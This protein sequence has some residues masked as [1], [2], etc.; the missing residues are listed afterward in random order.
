[1][2]ALAAPA[3][4]PVKPGDRVRTPAGK[5]RLS[6]VTLTSPGV[7]ANLAEAVSNEVY[8]GLTRTGRFTIVLGD[9]IALWLSQQAIAPESVIGGAGVK[10]ALDRFKSEHALVL[11]VHQ[12][13]RKPFMDARLFSAARAEP[14]LS[15]SAFVPP[16]VKPVQPGRFSGTVAA[17]AQ[18]EKQQRSLLA[19]LLGWGDDPTAYSAADS[20]IQL[21]EVARFPFALVGMDVAVSPADKIPRLAVTDGER[22]YMYRVVNRALEAEWTFYARWLGRVISVQLADL[23]GDGVLEVVAN[24]F[25]TKVGMSSLIVGLRKGK[26]EELADSYD[27]LLLAVDDEGKGIRHTLWAQRYVEE[28]FFNKGKAE[29][30]VLRNGTLAKQ[31]TVAVPDQFRATGATFATLMSKDARAL[32]YID[33]QGLLRV[34]TGTEEVWRSTTVVGGGLPKIEVVRYIERGGRSYF[35]RME[36]LPVAVDLDGDGLQEIVVPQ[37]QTESGLLAVLFRGPVGLRFQLV[38]SGFEGI[39]AGIGAIPADEGGPPSLMAGVV[40]YSGILRRGG[41]TQIIMAAPE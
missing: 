13:E 25:E 26:A 11:H 27:G 40:R 39:I 16:S 35:Y 7:R 41:E 37:N 29:Q 36:P 10:E 8:E 23:T 28:G 18:P 24:R 2:A 4:E 31:R 34:H 32:V 6:L 3:A 19:R 15:Q 14:L 5:V 30:Y 12:V 20:P 9:Q 22:I 33:D 21:K 1:M 38:N 17:A